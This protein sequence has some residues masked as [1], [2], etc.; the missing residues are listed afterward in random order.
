M[1]LPIEAF[2]FAGSCDWSSL[3]YTLVYH[4]EL[5]TFPVCPGDQ[6]IGGI[7]IVA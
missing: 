6:C 2:F 3:A 5:S 7:D 1:L 4:S